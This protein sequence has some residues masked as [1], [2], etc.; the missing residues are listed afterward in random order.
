MNVRPGLL[1]PETKSSDG[2][3]ALSH[4]HTVMRRPSVSPLG[5]RPSLE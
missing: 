4:T 1:A 5:N 3:G 2:V